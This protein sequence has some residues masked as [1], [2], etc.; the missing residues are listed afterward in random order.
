MS[1]MGVRQAAEFDFALERNG[2]T[3][4]DV[5]K[6]SGGE[7]LASLLF[8]VR[9]RAEVVAKSIFTLLR[10]VKIAA[11]PDVTTSKEYFKEAGV[12][13][14]G[15]NFEDQFYGLEVP[16]TEETELAVHR[17]EQASVD[18][19]ILAE[20]GNEAEISVSQ[21]RVFLAANRESQEWF[22]FYLRGR[23]GNIWAVH[24]CW[25]SFSREWHVRAYSVGYPNVWSQGF[26]VLSRKAA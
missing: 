7:L 13:V 19:P 22:I 20:L 26:L 14:A 3:S 4:E 23:D 15:S 21:F 17:L 11:Q 25:N 16:A 6:A 12:V 18:A 9:E 24:A 1:I 2:W 10:T 5:K 8:V